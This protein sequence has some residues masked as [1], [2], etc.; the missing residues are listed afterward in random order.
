MEGFEPNETA[1]ATTPATMA[2]TT[3][4]ER[5][6][7]DSAIPGRRRYSVL[8]NNNGGRKRPLP[9]RRLLS[10]IVVVV[11]VFVVLV[12]AVFAGPARGIGVCRYNLCV[13]DCICDYQYDDM[14]AI[15][16]GNYGWKVPPTAKD[17]VWNYMRPDVSLCQ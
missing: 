11:F 5:M 4:A 17:Y 12:L 15:E 8:R 14:C 9:A 1:T 3:T 2:V 13:P 6:D 16:Y 10:R 7:P